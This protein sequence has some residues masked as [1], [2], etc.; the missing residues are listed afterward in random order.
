MHGNTVNREERL[1]QVLSVR[2]TEYQTKRLQN[3]FRNFGLK[4]SSSEQLRLLLRKVH[5]SSVRYHNKHRELRRLALLKEEKL[6]R[7]AEEKAKVKAFE[8]AEWLKSRDEE[9][10]F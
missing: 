4:G 1:S 10:A 9:E 2:L 8:D 6:K 7:E 3:T 5:W